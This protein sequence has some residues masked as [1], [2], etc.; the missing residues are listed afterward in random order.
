MPGT[1]QPRNAIVTAVN[2]PFDLFDAPP[3]LA[4]GDVIIAIVTSRVSLDIEVSGGGS[5]SVLAEREDQNSLFTRVFAQ[6][7]GTS[8]PGSY[9]V[10]L[11]GQGVVALLHGRGATLA[12]VVLATASGI[13][14][15]PTEGALCPAAAGTVAAIEARYVVGDA[16]GFFGTDWGPLGYPAEDHVF[17]NIGAYLGAQ[18]TLSSATLPSRRVTPTA[19][20]VDVWQAWTIVVPPGDYVPPP[21]PVPAYAVKGRA[22]YRVTAHDMLTGAYID[23][24]YLRDWT[25][26]ARLNEPGPLTGS[27][28]IPNQRVARAVRRVIP[29]AKSDLS[30]GSGRVQIRV[31]RDGKLAGRYWLTGHRVA[32]GRDGKISIELRASKLD[33]FWFSLRIRVA[34]TYTSDL[35]AN[36]RALLQH[37]QALDGANIGV[38]FQSGV[39]GIS[40]TL[41]VTKEDNTT[42]GRRA[43]EALR[44]QAEYYVADTVDETGIR[45]TW[46]WGSPKIDTGIVHVFSSSPHGG[47]IAEYGVDVDALRGGTDWEVRGGTPQGEATTDRLPIYSA[48]VTTPHRAAGW[49]RIDHVVD[50][51]TQSLVQAELDTLAEYYAEMAGGGLWIRSV[52]V[53]LAKKTTLSLNS[54]GDTCRLMVTDVWHERI[55]GG[56]GLDITGRIIGIEIR[57]TGRGRGREEAVLTLE[58]VEVP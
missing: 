38:Q 13:F 4:P 22:L 41:A 58:S 51:P 17:G 20:L 2:G 49:P 39:A 29:K 48:P 45:S 11:D 40:N 32:R 6:Q 1:A 18:T 24:L 56:A 26:G 33:S 57:P 3:N 28:P 36:V 19:P 14:T 27:I 15:S 25:Y 9:A 52:T 37:G 47:D 34:L 46:V 55:D 44:G 5:W 7:V 43:Q 53:F 16:E 8:I 31:W 42:Y 10:E 30:T 54:L 21:P 12:G 23:D 35:I 50:H